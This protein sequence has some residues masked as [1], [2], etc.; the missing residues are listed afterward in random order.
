MMKYNEKIIFSN[1]FGTVS[2]KRIIINRKK[3][4]EN[5]IL[6]QISSVSFEYRRN[7]M[8][9][10]IYTATGIAFLIG[11]LNM[12]E[13]SGIVIFVSFIPIFFYIII[14]VS[15]YIGNHQIKISVAGKY[16]KPIRVEISKTK[17][18]REFANA[19]K[20]QIIS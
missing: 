16:Y 3:G 13:L 10:L 19:I 1:S 9:S 6:N 4:S 12:R 20:N 5:L 8:L 14:G 11:I 2:D 7:I 18:G 15:Y 17:E